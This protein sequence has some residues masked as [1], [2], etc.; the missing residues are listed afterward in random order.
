MKLKLIQ[1]E[2]TFD[3]KPIEKPN[4]IV[5]NSGPEFFVVCDRAKA[6]QF[7]IE[8]MKVGDGPAQWIC[9]VRWK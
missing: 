1:P 5:T 2:L 8:S 4:L 7:V 6:G 3:S 9:S